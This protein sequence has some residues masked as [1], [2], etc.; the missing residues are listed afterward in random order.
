MIRLIITGPVSPATRKRGA[1]SRKVR[2]RETEKLVCQY[3]L[4]NGFEGAHVTSAAASG[5][6]ILGIKGLDVEVKARRGFQPLA[7]MAQ[8]RARAKETGLGV[9]IMRMDSQGPSNMDDWVGIIRL[10]DLVYLLKAS[11]YG[12]R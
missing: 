5:S 7:A 6:D 2:G 4:N 10:A 3:F 9:A 1:V 12:Q 8:L 11:G